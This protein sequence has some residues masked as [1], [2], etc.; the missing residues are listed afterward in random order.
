MSDLATTVML[1]RSTDNFCRVLAGE[2]R[3]LWLEVRTMADT[4][5]ALYLEISDLMLQKAR[6]SGSEVLAVIP[7][8][9]VPG[10]GPAPPK[11]VS[12]V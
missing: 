8:P 7:Y 2:T 6:M 11:K 9:S 10:K 1:T 3:Q 5:R 12:A 4:R